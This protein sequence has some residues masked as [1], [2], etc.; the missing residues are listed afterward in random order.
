ME[1]KQIIV[2]DRQPELTNTNTHIF[3]QPDQDFLN[4]S[5]IGSISLL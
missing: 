2:A 4:Q 5:S 3:T 1:G